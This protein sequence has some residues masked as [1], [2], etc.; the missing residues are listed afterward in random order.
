MT[1]LAIFGVGTIGGGV[2]HLLNARGLVKKLVI[3]DR[4]QE[5]Q[6]AQR[7]DIIHT[8]TEV[9]I[10][11]NPGEISKC[12]I[13]ICSAGLPRNPSVKTR[14]DLL[15]T[16][17]PAAME[18]ARFLNGFEGILIVITNPMDII[19]YYLHTLTQLP[20]HRI[21]GFGGQ[22]DSARFTYA[23]SK[24]GIIETGTILGE[25]GEHQVPIFSRFQTE[26]PQDL[27][28]EILT[29]LRGASMEIIRGK[30]ATEFGP[31]WHISELVKAIVT[32][33]QVVIPCSCVLNGE[34]GLSKCSLGVP[35]I[36]GKNGISSI[37]KWNLDPWEQN[38]M[39]NAGAFVSEM[40]KELPTA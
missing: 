16:N 24:I 7:L 12:D 23:L 29:G 6:E 17:L 1:S 15:H 30:G 21:I 38:Q 14:A 32:D 20:R 19:T 27:R 8:G 36:I 33:A 5:L 35:A 22:L 3:Y 4:N 25:H 37:E 39:K 34:Y 9:T 28:E 31:T 40:I 26:C 18:C 2:A 10:S 11:T 13:V